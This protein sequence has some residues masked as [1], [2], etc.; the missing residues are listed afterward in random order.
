MKVALLNDNTAVSRLITLSLNKI[1]ASYIECDDIGSLSGD[2]DLIIIDSDI[3]LKPSDVFEFSNNVLCLVPRGSD[4]VDGA[5]AT[6]QKPFLPTEFIA[7]V[8]NIINKEPQKNENFIE[9]T[10]DVT[11]DFGSTLDMDIEELPDFDID[12][13]LDDAL[14][15]HELDNHMQ[16]EESIEENDLTLDIDIPTPADISQDSGESELDQISS[17]VDEIESMDDDNLSEQEQSKLDD[18]TANADDE[19]NLP[20]EIDEINLDDLV[21]D[22]ESSNSSFENEDTLNDNDELNLDNTQKDTNFDDELV[23]S[24][25]ADNHVVELSEPENDDIDMPEPIDLNTDFKDD[26]KNDEDFELV[27]NEIDNKEDTTFMDVG[28]IEN[29][30]DTSFDDSD[31]IQSDSSDDENINNTQLIDSTENESFEE[32]IKTTASDIPEVND[33]DEDSL[34]EELIDMLEDDLESE[35]KSD[36]SIEEEQIDTVQQSGLDSISEAEMME[37][38]GL[39]QQEE[40]V[41]SLKADNTERESNSGNLDLESIK[42]ELSNAIDDQIQNALNS[43]ELRQALKSMNIKINISFEEK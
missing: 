14:S 8:D 36:I 2:Y 13:S 24:I 23:D 32:E 30:I 26:L 42:H 10:I 33:T 11:K 38:L 34:D 18:I 40:N 29:E 19:N 6:L 21:F 1:G 27:D 4:N 9:N 17:L 7:L 20:E 12:T 16:L 3:N 43:S 31:N 22:I 35:I 28:N 25:Y 41:D 5:K 39:S 37:A 15:G